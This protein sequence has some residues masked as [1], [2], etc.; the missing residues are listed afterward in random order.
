MKTMINQK[1]RLLYLKKTTWI[2]IIV[3]LIAGLT[4]YW[5]IHSE[6]PWANPYFE[7]NT[8][9]YEYFIQIQGGASG[10]MLLLLPLL[11]TL[12]TGDFFIKNRRSSILSYSL[13]RTNLK[14]YIK[15]ELVSTGIISFLFVVVCQLLLL[16][17]ALLFTQITTVNPD[18]GL[19]TFAVDFLYRMPILYVLMIIINSGL[20]AAFF[21]SF[22][23]GISIA[24]K[25]IYSAMLLPYLI[26]IGISE[27]M[28]TMPLILD[29]SL[30][31]WLFR[32]SP[33][34]M[35]GDYVSSLLPL[36]SVPIYWLILNIATYSIVS[37][38]FKE[39]FMKEKLILN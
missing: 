1:L 12:S 5:L 36:M 27:I 17:C 7:F 25:N 28:M 21:S 19:V 35:T 33:L 34:A 26:F 10:F 32:F 4:N 9:F 38:Y 37:T 18:Q 15:K 30:G 8:S 13:T 2:A 23:I 31:Q 20:M 6:L 39:S 29:S 3:Y 16:V 24:F 22:T 14:T 11:V